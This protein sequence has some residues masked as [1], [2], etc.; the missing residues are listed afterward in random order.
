MTVNTTQTSVTFNPVAS[1]G[2]FAIP[3]PFL[4]TSDLLVTLA[5]GIKV[6]GVDY[7]VSLA[8]QTVTFLSPITG[9]LVILR[10]VAL[11][12]PTA[13]RNA[14]YF[15]PATLETALDRLEMQIQQ[16]AIT[17]GFLTGTCALTPTGF[18]D[19]SPVTATWV[20]LGQVVHILVPQIFRTSNATG[21]SLS[22]IPLAQR[23]PSSLHGYASGA[24]AGVSVAL[25]YLVQSSGLI[26]FSKGIYGGA[27]TASGSKILYAC[28]ISYVLA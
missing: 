20:Q 27:F 11:S 12:Q 5:G 10:T 23:P 2:P 16:G 4:A 19:N 9:A 18:T 7:T 15:D 13:F 26:T 25:E 3:Y 14:G 17:A 24:D 22:G 6:E 8:G 28:S 21:F 1:A